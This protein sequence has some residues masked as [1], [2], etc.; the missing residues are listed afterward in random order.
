MR[1]RICRKTVA[2][3]AENPAWPLCSERCRLIDLGRWMSEDYVISSPL[4]G[5]EVPSPPESGEE[6]SDG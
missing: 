1:C 3:R 4:F 5:P 6:E 2:P